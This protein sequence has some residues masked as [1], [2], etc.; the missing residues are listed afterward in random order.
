MRITILVG[1][2]LL[3]PTGLMG[4]VGP[5]YAN[6]QAGY[7]NDWLSL[8]RRP[9]DPPRSSPG[10]LLLGGAVG[11]GL[12]IAASQVAYHWS[13]GGRICGD[14]PCGMVAGLMTLILLEP[15][16]IP[17][18]VHL[19]DRQRGSFG[20]ALFASLLSGAAALYVGNWTNLGH[21]TLVLVPVVQ[22]VASALIE[23]A[24]EGGDPE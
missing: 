10:G 15:I 23:R 24:S 9:A 13:G 6:L 16:L 21:G 14:D 11:V 1:M 19:A 4:Q 7:S 12:A 3:A 2:V 22:I 20:G 17:V 5:T 8:A 18:G